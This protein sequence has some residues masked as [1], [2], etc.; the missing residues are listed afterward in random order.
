MPKNVREW[1][2]VGGFFV[3]A[4]LFAVVVPPYEAPDE[5]HHLAYI[6]YVAT[7]GA[8]P[9]Q[10]REGRTVIGEGHQYPLYYLLAG[11]LV[12]AIHPGDAI[13]VDQVPNPKHALTPGGS[14]YNVPSFRHD[15]VGMFPHTSDRFAFYFL[16][17]LSALL[18]AA[19]VWFIYR[20]GAMFIP[21]PAGRWLGVCWAAANP[22]FLYSAAS[23]SNDA[24]ANALAAAAAYVLFKSVNGA[25]SSFS[26]RQ[27]ACLGA[28]LG[29]GAL[30]KKSSLSLVAAAGVVLLGRCVFGR[31]RPNLRR[32]G[33]F[34]IVVASV[35]I[36]VSGWVFLRNHR[37]YGDWLGTGMEKTTLGVL[38]LV[39][40]KSLL[41]EYFFTEFPRRLAISFFGVFGLWALYLPLAVY[42][43]HGL[44][45]ASAA[46]GIFMRLK[47]ARFFDVRIFAPAAV[48]LMQVAGVGY[49]NL[50]YTQPQG[51][52]LFPALG[53]MAVLV[54]SGLAA[55]IARV[56]PP[57][58]RRAAVATLIAA[59][60]LLAILALFRVHDFY[61]DPSSYA[62]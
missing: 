13:R 48:L 44:V 17:F 7:R 2:L 25:V 35:F 22:Q 26:T 61:S 19:T 42:L 29:A 47:K 46:G 38:G 45:I 32:F 12:R 33:V 11:G 4:A 28:V 41:S 36:A 3:M 57:C 8:L 31:P 5:E 59:F 43:Y 55:L 62:G 52:L 34:L 40:E 20:L 37:L 27:A 1:G 58:V 51:R 18:G 60:V 49:Y 50:T 30:A 21:D 53:P 39:Q 14:S 6:N 10:L 15:G 9:N 54:G 16:R 56:A 24:L 23:I